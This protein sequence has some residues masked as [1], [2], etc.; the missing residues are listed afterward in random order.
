VLP[1]VGESVPPET[2]I[3]PPSVTAEDIV[4]N[5]PPPSSMAPEFDV[6]NVPPS[7]PPSVKSSMPLAAL[8]VP[9]LS[10]A[11]ATVLVPLPPVLASVP[12]LSNVLP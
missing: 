5:V 6:A 7:E 2:R 3:L 10:R 8:T 11:A 12:T 4:P 9:V 1:V